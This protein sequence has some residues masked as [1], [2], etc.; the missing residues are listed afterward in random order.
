[1]LFLFSDLIDQFLQSGEVR[2]ESL[3]PFPGGFDPGPGSSTLIPLVDP[4]ITRLFEDPE[5]TA[6]IPVAQIQSV[7]EKTEVRLVSLCEN[8]EDSETNPLMDGVVE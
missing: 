8:G 7:L 2:P 5:M 4:D 6:Q 3:T 1:M